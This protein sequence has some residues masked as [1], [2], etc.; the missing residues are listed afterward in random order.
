MSY[1]CHDCDAII[2]GAPAADPYVFQGEQYGVCPDC[3][4]KSRTGLL[5]TVAQLE[6]SGAYAWPGGYPV[7]FYPPGGGSAL[8][9]DCAKTDLENGDGPLMAQVEDGDGQYYGGVT[10]DGCGSYIVE[11]MCPECGDEL[12]DGTPLVSADNVDAAF[13]HTRCAA[14][15]VCERKA[16][17]IPGKGVR[18]LPQYPVKYGWDDG[19]PWYA[20]ANTL[21]KYAR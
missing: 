1:Q 10:C 17:R 6:K 16:A 14:K 5:Y 11:P 4:K 2:D 3:V 8:C 18:I 20:R 13:M 15:L 12:F 9:F 21:Y 19:S 7:A